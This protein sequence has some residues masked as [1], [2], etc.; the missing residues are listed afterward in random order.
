MCVKRRYIPLDHKLGEEREREK[1]KAKA[2][3]LNGRMIDSRYCRMY[4][5]SS[6]AS[7]TR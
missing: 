5:T 3:I 4:E 1:P 2:F 6:F 7:G